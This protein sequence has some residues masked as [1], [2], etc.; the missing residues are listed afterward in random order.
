MARRPL[1]WR[2]DAG[3]RFTL[4]SSQWTRQAWFSPV[5]ENKR[6][7]FYIFRPDSKSIS[8]AAF[9]Y[10]QAHLLETFMRHLFRFYDQASATSSA[11]ELDLAA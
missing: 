9:V 6:L 2:Y 7:V 5:V 4:T 1:P 3:G 11:G 8:R 10:Y